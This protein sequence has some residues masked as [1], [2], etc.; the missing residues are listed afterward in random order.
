LC[1]REGGRGEGV[2]R[3]RGKMR[4]RGRERER[5]ITEILSPFF[6]SSAVFF[7]CSVWNVSLQITKYLLHHPMD[8]EFLHAFAYFTYSMKN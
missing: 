3:D 7:R 5:G 4:D 6:L 1:T 8:G 2:E